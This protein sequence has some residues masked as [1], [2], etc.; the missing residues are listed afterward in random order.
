MESGNLNLLQHSGPHRACYEDP[1][2]VICTAA[3]SRTLTLSFQL[4]VVQKLLLYIQKIP[5]EIP[6][7]IA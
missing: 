3:D 7:P 4:S 2:I 5:D 6:D 1:K